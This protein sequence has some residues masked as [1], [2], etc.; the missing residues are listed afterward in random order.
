MKKLKFEIILPYYK[1]PKIVLNTL[2]SIKKSNYDNWHLTFIDDSGDDQFKETLLNFGF[3]QS[4][5]S[6]VPIM[7]SDEEKINLGGSFHGKYMNESIYNS[8]SDIIIPLCDDDALVCDYMEKLNEYYNLNESVM[9]SYCHLNFYDPYKENYLDSK[10]ESENPSLNYPYLNSNIEPLNPYMCKDFSQVTF[11][12]N[13]IVEKKIEYPYPK[14]HDL[15]AEIFYYF[16]NSWGPCHFNGLR[17]QHKGWH[18]EQLG[19]RIRSG[20]GHF[21]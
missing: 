12:K 9:W 20:R 1:R 11:R 21:I 2:D 8:D 18:Q 15:D 17:G 5:I 10:S 4:K 14:N 6:Y 19:V 3:D 16:F 7:M 13:A